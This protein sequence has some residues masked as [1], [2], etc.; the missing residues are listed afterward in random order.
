V[1]LY[2]LP[3]VLIA[4]YTL[5]RRRTQTDGGNGFNHFS[6]LANK[7]IEKVE[8][9]TFETPDPTSLEFQRLFQELL[10]DSLTSGRRL[11]LVIDNLDRVESSD[12]LKLWSAIHLFV[13]MSPNTQLDWGE[14]FW[15]LVPFDPSG[16]NRLWGNADGGEPAGQVFLEKTFQVRFFVPAPILSDWQSFM[17]SQLKAA[18]PD[19]AEDDL[20]EIARI[21]GILRPETSQPPTP[22][23][24]KTFIN[25]VGAA[26]RS[27][28]EVVVSLP[29]TALYVA[30][31]KDP[32]WTPS[33]PLSDDILSKLQPFLDT[34]WSHDLAALYYNVPKDKAVQV[35][36]GSKVEA[37]LTEGDPKAL[38]EL[39]GK[40][41][42]DHIVL[43]ILDQRLPQWTKSE[44]I[45]IG[46]AA[47]ACE[48]AG[49]TDAQSWKEVWSRLIGGAREVARWPKLDGRSGRGLAALVRRQNDSKFTQKILGAVRAPQLG[50]DKSEIIGGE[51]QGWAAGISK[52]LEVASAIG[53]NSVLD[54]FRL[55]ASGS[56][57]VYLMAAMWSLPDRSQ[58]IS[59]LRPESDAREVID[60]LLENASTGSF[61]E[62]QEHASKIM[63]ETGVSWDWSR[64]ADGIQSRLQQANCSRVEVG[65]LIR[66]LLQLGNVEPASLKVLEQIVRSGWTFHHLQ[67]ASQERH[68]E[69]MASCIL[70]AILYDP[71]AS[72]P[73]PSLAN[74]GKRVYRSIV[75]TPD[76]DEEVLSVLVAQVIDLQLSEKLLVHWSEV[77]LPRPVLG[78]IYKASLRRPDA[79]QIFSSATLITQSEVLRSSE[80]GLWGKLLESAIKSSPLLDD[81][82]RLDFSLQYVPLYRDLLRHSHSLVLVSYLVAGIQGLPKE[83]WLAALASRSDLVL[84]TFELQ[85]LGRPLD[86]GHP[87][88][89]ALSHIADSALAGNEPTGVTTEDCVKLFGALSTTQCEIFRRQLRDDLIQAK[90][91][92]AT[93]LQFFGP[94]LTDCNTMG[95]EAEKLVREAFAKILDRK[96][97]IETE[98]LKSLLVKCPDI[99]HKCKPASLQDFKGRIQSIQ[100]EGVGDDLKEA[101]SGIANLLQVG[102]T[103]G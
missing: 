16:V 52:I 101:F 57:Y 31:T 86:L 5:L 9:E 38:A 24:L 53:H 67:M 39:I 2:L 35:L 10:S 98:W 59:Y 25:Q 93:L 15:T 84:L 50:P 103:R 27:S 42:V 1:V 17:T 47:Y 81:L 43:R 78:E 45:T 92:T 95:E 22:R 89:D 44:S 83:Q 33:T 91:S 56:D 74:Q 23:E 6:L 87:L 82:V 51:A 97:R 94:L 72:S 69:T 76:Q 19:H 14:R 55:G 49:V 3:L 21:F 41:G 32:K 48:E 77:S 46:R 75:E 88:R 8:T 29:L 63:V 71:E 64:L 30:L 28:P 54:S 11:L 68:L 37:S 100:D 90:S 102:G 4:L 73:M 34:D 20:Y 58:V 36:F 40:P 99:V 12:A 61:E 85:E 26:F 79:Y 62:T 13:D 96:D 18:F 60:S 65:A 66:T 80:E 70:A 7:T